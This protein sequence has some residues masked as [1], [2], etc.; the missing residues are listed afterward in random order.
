MKLKDKVVVI[1]GSTRGIGRAI[2]DE[3]GKEGAK[4]VISSRKESSVN[5]T[6]EKIKNNGY[7]VT[8]I[9]SDVSQKADL[10]KLLIHAVDTFGKIDVWINN[11]GLSSGFR[12][13]TEIEDDEIVSLVN[14]NLTGL[15]L[16]SKIVIGYFK[17]HN[18]GILINMSGKG[19]DGKASPN[20]AVY[21]A[22]KSA[23][24]SISK[25]L[26]AEYKNYPISIHSLLPG[27][28]K[29][30]FY[31]DIKTTPE[32]KNNLENMDLIL[33]AFGVPIEE[34]ARFT[35]EIAAQEPGKV[36]GKSY[37]LLKGKRL[38][39]GIL[40]MMWYRMRGKMKS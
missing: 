13:L 11:A 33:N 38:F 9:V 14:V 34:V 25:S 23:V 7:K 17:K 2:A 18:G 31:V 30:D 5:K 29:T 28:V 8:G 10:E 1:T 12:P 27:M 15:L 35:A 40:L 21:A 26:A 4:V 36:T 32:L 16:A 37:S 39:R 3:C 19:W 6:L 22:T 24:T 20:T